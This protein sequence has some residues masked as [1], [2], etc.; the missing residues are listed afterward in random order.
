MLAF[1]EARRAGVM[2]SRAGLLCFNWPLA[3]Y[4]R[5]ETEAAG[6]GKAPG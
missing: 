4:L 1:E 5:A 6:L 3:A 2:G